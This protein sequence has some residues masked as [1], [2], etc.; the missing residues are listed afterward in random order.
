VYGRRASHA[1]RTKNA[2]PKAL[3]RVVGRPNP[4]PFTPVQSVARSPTKL[5]SSS[6][7]GESFFSLWRVVGR[8]NP[9]SRSSANQTRSFYSLYRVARQTGLASV[10]LVAGRIVGRPNRVTVHPGRIVGRQ[11]RVTVREESSADRILSVCGRE[12]RWVG[13]VP[14]VPSTQLFEPT[15]SADRAAVW[16]RHRSTR[17]GLRRRLRRASAEFVHSGRRLLNA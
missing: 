2:Q 14:P 8:P 11:N 17:R 12:C 7:C 16:S 9:K 13:R 5:A 10:S 1:H 15:L 4:L 3:W 6:R